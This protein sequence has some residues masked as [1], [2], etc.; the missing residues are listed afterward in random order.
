MS[1]GRHM[2]LPTEL[3]DKI[4]E[5]ADAKTYYVIVLLCKESH[6]VS[7]NYSTFNN[8]CATHGVW[9]LPNNR[10][11]NHRYVRETKHHIIF[12]DCY[13]GIYGIQYKYN[14]IRIRLDCASYISSPCTSIYVS[15]A[16]A[17]IV[18]YGHSKCCLD[19]GCT[20]DSSKYIKTIMEREGFTSL[21]STMLDSK[22]RG[23]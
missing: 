20:L 12:P 2:C 11:K 21:N 18:V 9:R 13:A 19:N 16:R 7:V 6:L 17:V 23:G 4:A 5:D 3:W 22:H 1:L 14:H 15:D 8:I 10:I